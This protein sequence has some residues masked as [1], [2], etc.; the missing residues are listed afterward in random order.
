MTNN[1]GMAMLIVLGLV[2]MLL[3]LGGAVLM[4]STG[5]F[6]TTFHQV[7]RTKA[8]Y[9]TEAAMQHTLWALRTGQ[10][11]GPVSGSTSGTFENLFPDAAPFDVNGV[12]GDQVQITISAI[13][14]SVTDPDGVYPVDIKVTY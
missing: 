8:Y 12:K 5:H 7:S 13:D 9:A 11:V 6:G 1:K 10:L 2:I 4:I 3:V 14:Y